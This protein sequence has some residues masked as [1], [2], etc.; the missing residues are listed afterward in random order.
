[1]KNE[2]HPVSILQTL[3]W[4]DHPGFG[5]KDHW[6]HSGKRRF[7]VFGTLY[8][9]IE[10]RGMGV[11]STCIVSLK[12]FCTILCS[13]VYIYIIKFNYIYIYMLVST[14]GNMHV[15][16]CVPSLPSLSLNIYIS[17]SLSVQKYLSMR[18][19]MS[20]YLSFHPFMYTYIN[21]YLHID[22]IYYVHTRV[23]V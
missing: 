8:R 16:Y 9:E 22:I 4:I 5:L 7:S 6:E 2:I 21:V 17:L 20:L 10:I 13:H 1:M 12:G 18:P 15:L 3:K 14:L 11:I 19:S 23:Y